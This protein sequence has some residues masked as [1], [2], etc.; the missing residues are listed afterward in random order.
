MR[1][2]VA[3]SL[4]GV[5]AEQAAQTLTSLGVPAAIAITERGTPRALPE[6]YSVF[7]GEA[8]G[9]APTTFDSGQAA[10]VYVN[11]TPAPVV[12]SGQ[13]VASP[14]GSGVQACYF[15]GTLSGV[16]TRIGGRFTFPAGSTSTGAAALAITNASLSS[17]TATDMSC[18][19]VIAPT[20][21][22]F[23]VWAGPNNGN[24]GIQYLG[25]TDF[26]PPLATDGLT[27]Y[28][29]EVFINGTTAEIHLPDGT[30]VSVTDSRIGDASY[31]GPNVFFEQYANDAD[32]D[33]KVAFTHVWAS[34]GMSKPSQPV[35]TGWRKAAASVATAPVA[36]PAETFT[37]IPLPGDGSVTFVAPPSGQV[38]ARVGAT[39]DVTTGT[40]IYLG[41]RVTPT[42]AL[43]SNQVAEAA[44]TNA[45]YQTDIIVPNLTPGVVYAL[46]PWVYSA[47]IC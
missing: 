9:A 18:H 26:N 39:L 1:R 38:I 14:T 13:L 47:P 36:V 31:G 42:S 3:C 23:A 4:P 40:L 7:A 12:S 6:L 41:V 44:T 27:E 43:W 25:G 30:T 19:L 37:D 11:G 35:F 28:E 33:N 5:V 17:E 29:A 21:W 22:T 34:S 24:T 20:S 32:T 45:Y 8:D 10:S 2:R 46:N 16:G 15:K